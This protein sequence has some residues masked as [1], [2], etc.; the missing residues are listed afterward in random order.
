M[1]TEPITPS[2]TIS[3]FEPIAANA[4]DAPTDDNMPAMPPA[5]VSFAT[6]STACHNAAST[7]GTTNSP[8]LAFALPDIDV[9]CSAAKPLSFKTFSCSSG[10]A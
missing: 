4:C 1:L 2:F 6:L 5:E 9:G 3:L 8:I 7:F 10:V